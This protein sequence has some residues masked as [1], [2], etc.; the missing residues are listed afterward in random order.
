MARIREKEIRRRRQRK[1]R[2]GKLKQKLAS[3]KTIAER[4]LLI[5]QIKK[6][7]PYFVPPE[8]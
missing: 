2:I 7:D 6:R 3:A 1:A 5:E 8:K 4:E